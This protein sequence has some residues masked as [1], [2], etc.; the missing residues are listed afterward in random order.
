M[1][2]YNPCGFNSF[3]SFN[4]YAFNAQQMSSQMSQQ[5][6]QMN[7]PQQTMSSTQNDMSISYVQTIQQVEQVQVQP[8]QRRLILVQNEPVV[9]MRVADGMGLTTT[10]YYKL[11]KFNPSADMN[12]SNES[13]KYV[14]EEQLEERLKI[15]LDSLKKESVKTNESVV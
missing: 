1:Y 12:A 6:Q 9:A 7:N 2:E 5:M 10:E 8:N 4:P 11:T 15:L 14:T 13:G 3:N